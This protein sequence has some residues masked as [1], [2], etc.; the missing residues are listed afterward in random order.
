[1]KRRELLT[2]LGG[3]MVAGAPRWLLAQTPETPAFDAL[4]ARDPWLTGWKIGRA[5]CRERV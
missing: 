3:A 4:A 5:S 1:M 2:L